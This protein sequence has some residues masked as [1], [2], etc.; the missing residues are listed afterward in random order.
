MHK[1]HCTHTDLKP[2]NILIQTEELKK[3][4]YIKNHT[5]K[6][7][8]HERSSTRSQSRRSGNSFRYR[9]QFIYEPRSSKITIIDMG[10]ATWDNDY[11]NSII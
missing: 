10:G 5:K 8:N 11:H 7:R 4:P 3:V 1:N 9:G 6:D 2:E